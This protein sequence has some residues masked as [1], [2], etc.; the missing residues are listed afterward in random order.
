MEAGVG[1]RRFFNCFKF[2]AIKYAVDP[3]EASGIGIF[4]VGL[5]EGH[6]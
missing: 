6:E 3:K 5:P 2:L 4:E 1:N